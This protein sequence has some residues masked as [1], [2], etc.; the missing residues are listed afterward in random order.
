MRG[1]TRTVLMI[2]FCGL[3]A[4]TTSLSVRSNPP[5]AEVGIILPN[6]DTPKVIGQT[7]L[8]TDLDEFDSAV[9][10]GTVVVVV[11]K[12]GYISQRFVVPNLSMAKLDIE[13]NLLPHLRSDYEETNRII[14]LAFKAERHLMQKQP[15]EAL[16]LAKEIKKINENIAAA[17]QIEGA[18]Y[19]LQNDFRKAKIAWIR[20][21][22]LQ[23]NNHDARKMLSAVEEKLS[24]KKKRN[25]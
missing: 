13:A 5:Q 10:V 21:I 25:N 3:G 4:C 14:S 6:R 15:K 22:E 19:F 12:P 24:G 16:E 23:P 17:F 20:T 18:S 9:D 1:I 11:Q 8:D 2:L 7:P